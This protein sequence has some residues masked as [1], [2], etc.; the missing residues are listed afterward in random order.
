MHSLAA[1]TFPLGCPATQVGHIVGV[2]KKR[3]EKLGALDVLIVDEASQTCVP[4]WRHVRCSL[5]SLP[6]VALFAADL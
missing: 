2:K 6:S 4:R 3:S 5:P 1:A